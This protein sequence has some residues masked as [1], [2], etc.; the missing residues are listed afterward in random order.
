[1]GT[2]GFTLATSVAAGFLSAT[3]AAA[4]AP[5]PAAEI[6]LTTRGM[7]KGLAQTD[8]PQALLRAEL[9]VGTLF[10][11]AYGKN[12]V[13][14]GDDGIEAGFL[15][16]ARV[17]WSGFQLSASAA[18]KRLE[19]IGGGVDDDALELVLGLSRRAGPLTVRASATWSPDELGSTRR[20]LYVETGLAIDLGR[21]TSLS[22][23]VG[24][25]ER[26]GGPDYTALNVGLTQSLWRGI[27]AD[28]RYFDTA[29]GALGEVYRARLVGSLRARF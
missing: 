29:Q 23:N 13:S 7:S 8:G 16:G 2:S 5:D 19:G 4:Q 3:P 18:Y 10:I 27:S 24:R 6:V 21:G 12:V 28:L 17:D 22:A 26:A 14:S 1:M 9:A 15:A 25:R 11:A 20:S